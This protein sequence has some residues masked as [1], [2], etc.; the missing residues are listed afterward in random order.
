MS[1]R[2]SARSGALAGVALLLTSALSGA[3]KN[4]AP[5]ATF[6]GS[7]L[8]GWR[9]LGQADWRAEN[10]EIIGTPKGGTAAGGWLILDRAYQDVAVVS[11][12]RCTGGCTT[13]VLLR[14]EQ[15]ADGGLKGIFVSIADGNIT[16]YRV[17]L[18]AR[19]VETSRERLRAP[20]GGQ[21]RVIANGI[22][23]AIPATL[24]RTCE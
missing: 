16:A 19:G 5:D 21:L 7:S 24:A 4:F 13:G 2:V 14:A 10:G 15:A 6:T 22:A 23:S 8:T 18:D 12:I 3:S 11:S 17:T 9:V 20:G 1:Y